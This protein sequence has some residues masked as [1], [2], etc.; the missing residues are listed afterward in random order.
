MNWWERECW[1]AEKP[2][3]IGP[4]PLASLADKRASMRLRKEIAHWF[5][6]N[7]CRSE[8]MQ[9]WHKWEEIT[10]EVQRVYVDSADHI[11]SIICT[12]IEGVKNPYEADKDILDRQ[13]V[14]GAQYEAIEEF[15]Q[16]IL[17]RLGGKCSD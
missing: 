3:G 9:S 10:E 16:S 5:Y 6:E 17:Q 4:L 1:D 12:D 8:G 14:Q 11:T 15:R 13:T 2:K 7:Q